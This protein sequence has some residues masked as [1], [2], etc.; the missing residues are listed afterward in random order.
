MHAAEIDNIAKGLCRICD[1]RGREA[2][3]LDPMKLHLLRRPGAIEAD[4]LD[5]IVE[6]LQPGMAKLRPVL[7]LVL[8]VSLVLGLGAFVVSVMLDSRPGA[9][10]D[11]ISTV[12][13]PAIYAPNLVVVAL[14]PWMFVHQRRARRGR[15]SAV[16]IKFRRCPHCGYSLRGLPV[17]PADGATV[18][19]ECACAWRLDDP[20]LAARATAL[21]PAA[22]GVGGH[23]RA[24]LLVLIGLTILAVG[25]TIMLWRSM[26]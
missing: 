7:I 3:Q 18:C 24:I 4:V 9:W 26:P 20:K 25:G 16:L 1:A 5:E 11:L 8:V 6:E 23:S 21:D 10:K 19:P 15:V 14:I 12:T 17:D 13:N 22:A 2:S